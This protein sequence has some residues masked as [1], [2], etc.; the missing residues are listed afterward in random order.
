[1]I[2]IAKCLSKCRFERFYSFLYWEFSYY[3]ILERIQSYQVVTIPVG[4]LEEFRFQKSTWFDFPRGVKDDLISEGIFN[5]VLPFKINFPQLLN[6]RWKV[7]EL[8]FRTLPWGWDQIENTFRHLA[9]FKDS[10]QSVFNMNK[11][12]NFHFSTVCSNEWLY[13]V[14]ILVWWY[15]YPRPLYQQKVINVRLWL[16]R[17]QDCRNLGG[18]GRAD[19]LTLS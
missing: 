11:W 18:S 3:K 14:C 9:T 17:V 15:I 1:M 7:E 13:F 5:L 8:W 6:Q 19:Y 12:S 10:P 16:T 4:Y 2:S